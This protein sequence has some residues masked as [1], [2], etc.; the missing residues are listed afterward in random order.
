MPSAK[1]YALEAMT[2]LTFPPCGLNIFILV[3]FYTNNM[4]THSCRRVKNS[5]LYRAECEGENYFLYPVILV[6]RGRTPGRK[7]KRGQCVDFQSTGQRAKSSA[8]WVRTIHQA[9]P[10][11]FIEG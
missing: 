2:W 5:E 1:P 7:Q 11:I 3:Y 6:R 10:V 4:G 9:A 8:G